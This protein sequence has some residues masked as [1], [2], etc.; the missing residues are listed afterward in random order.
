MCRK[1]IGGEV[2]SHFVVPKGPVWL[3]A[4]G[5]YLLLSHTGVVILPFRLFGTNYFLGGTKQYIA[6]PQIGRSIASWQVPTWDDVNFAS[7]VSEDGRMV[8]IADS[9]RIRVYQVT[10]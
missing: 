3:G 5:D 2:L 1:I 7:A 4:A 6:D 10:H 8:V 9:G